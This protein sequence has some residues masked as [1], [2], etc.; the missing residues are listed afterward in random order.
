VSQNGPPR[1]NIKKNVTILRNSDFVHKKI[2]KCRK[3]AEDVRRREE[4]VE[5]VGRCRKTSEASECVAGERE[6]FQKLRVT[7]RVMS[8]Y[9]TVLPS[10]GQAL[11]G[12]SGW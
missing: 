12:R 1:C 3:I 11:E 10:Y 5:G 2:S 9:M 7:D 4:A 6:D 8:R